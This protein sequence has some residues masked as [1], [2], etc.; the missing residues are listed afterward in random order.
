MLPPPRP[1]VGPIAESP[2]SAAATRGQKLRR[3]DFE[4]WRDFLKNG[5]PGRLCKL[6]DPQNGNRENPDF[7]SVLK[8]AIPWLLTPRAKH[9][10]GQGLDIWY[11]W[12]DVKQA[13]AVHFAAMGSSSKQALE[14]MVATCGAK[15]VARLAACPDGE[16][17][18]ALHLAAREGQHQ[19][20]AVLLA[21]ELG[22][23]FTEATKAVFPPPSTVQG[24]EFGHLRLTGVNAFTLKWATDLTEAGV[25][26][27][28]RRTALSCAAEGHNF[29]AVRQLIR[30]GADPN[31]P[32]ET[33]LKVRLCTNFRGTG[34][35]SHG[36]AC[37]FAHGR[38]QLGQQIIS[39]TTGAAELVV[40]YTT[41]L[42]SWYR[43]ELPEV[44]KA[45]FETLS[46]LMAETD[47]TVLHNSVKHMLQHLKVQNGED[48]TLRQLAP[49]WA[50]NL[51]PANI[52]DAS[53]AWPSDGR[54][55]VAFAS[56][57]WPRLV[58]N[59]AVASVD[60]PLRPETPTGSD[61]GR[62]GASSSTNAPVAGLPSPPSALRSERLWTK[63]RSLP[64]V[65][66]QL[67]GPLQLDTL[68]TLA[69]HAHRRDD[70]PLKQECTL[71]DELLKAHPNYD[72]NAGHSLP[73]NVA[74]EH[75]N[76]S[77]VHL[78][79]ERGADLQR[80]DAPEKR[81]PLGCA[82]ALLSQPLRGQTPQVATE[83]TTSRYFAT[84]R[85][86]MK[87]MTALEQQ[88]AGCSPP[89]D[90]QD[91]RRNVDEFIR[92]VRRQPNKTEKALIGSWTAVLQ[93]W[94]AVS[95]D[96]ALAT[97]SNLSPVLA[98]VGGPPSAVVT[99]PLQPD[100][101]D[102]ASSRA[103]GVARLRA[104]EE[105]GAVVTPPSAAVSFQLAPPFAPVDVSEG[106]RSEVPAAMP[107]HEAAFE[108]LPDALPIAITRMS[109]DT[110][111]T[112]L[113]DI[114]MMMEAFIE[115]I[116]PPTRLEQIDVTESSILYKAQWRHEGAEEEVVIKQLN[117]HIL[118]TSLAEMRE[119][120]FWREISYHKYLIHENIIPL[121]GIYIYEGPQ[122]EVYDPDGPQQGKRKG[123]MHMVFPYVK[124]GSLAK[125]IERMRYRLDGHGKKVASTV[126]G[127]K[128]CEHPEHEYREH[129][130]LRFVHRTL[131]GIAKAVAF[132]HHKHTR[133]HVIHR[134]LK[135]ENVLMDGAGGLLGY[136][137]KLTDFGLA[138]PF[139]RETR[140]TKVLS[141]IQIAA[142]EMMAADPR[143]GM[144]VDSYAFGHLIW[145]LF[146]LE[147]PFSELRQMP[148]GAAGS[149][150]TA[151]RKM[152]NSCA[153]GF[154]EMVI[155]VFSVPV[156]SV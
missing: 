101:I 91:I 47:R 30:D 43:K 136:T 103:E 19:F 85:V 144:P 155:V 7:S 156:A 82:A 72:V 89:P 70:D 16:G 145:E 10:E 111:T 120:R 141:T 95:E 60:P 58:Q 124:A 35:C 49:L 55:L 71:L 78:L 4:D 106:G 128:Y 118:Q 107:F 140:M 21:G 31:Q 50:A 52:A 18:N 46:L 96:G 92:G 98:P 26:L 6:L 11:L 9:K 65:A 77:A 132:L 41:A 5:G 34:Q 142:P 24:E 40:A 79:L 76:V 112:S 138:R 129:A 135:S 57:W 99:P 121:R 116:E 68:A 126:P 48:E 153:S 114:K 100:V 94:P 33:M 104:L 87:I 62:R 80:I 61:D 66:L 28:A 139:N 14:L 110:A 8:S 108:G 90:W 12:G 146:R 73:L 102:P 59:A 13:S 51:L 122:D 74:I 154:T 54:F 17:H 105:I 56:Y 15:A 150:T 148:E 22:A 25:R 147:K 42:Q 131:L 97:P 83:A 44:S 38:E 88:R 2:H 115:R 117:P 67:E 64:L 53:M 36:T 109:S 134:D 75:L 20:I 125:V 32:V 86:L 1:A 63:L 137:A 29:G 152:R 84:L 113:E 119:I 143:Y 23:A 149:E 93:D 3:F 69:I 133:L 81:S 151:I 123:A 39:P 37:F 130:S 45:A 27:L 127:A